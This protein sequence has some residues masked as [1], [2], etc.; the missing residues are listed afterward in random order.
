MKPGSRKK[1]HNFGKRMDVPGGRREAP[2]SDIR[3]AVS[4]HAVNCS[5]PVTLLDVSR[6][7]ARMS[8]PEPM[9]RGQQVWL[10]TPAVQ[11]FGFVCWVRGRNCGIRFDEPLTDRHLSQLKLKGQVLVA[12]GRSL[13]ERFAAL[14]WQS[15]L[16]R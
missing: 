14:T 2:R 16:I 15:S 3:L 4:L 13:D 8:M 11:L 6:T 5:H 1:V 12:S 10:K 9:Y 7:G